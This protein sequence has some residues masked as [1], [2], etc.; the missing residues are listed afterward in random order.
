MSEKSKQ[1]HNMVLVMCGESRVW[2]NSCAKGYR[3]TKCS[4]ESHAKAPDQR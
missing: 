3:C 2:A 4:S 1:V